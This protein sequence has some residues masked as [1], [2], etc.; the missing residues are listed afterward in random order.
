V[1]PWGRRRRTAP[2]LDEDPVYGHQIGPK[3]PIL[4]A[5]LGRT[6]RAAMQVVRLCVR[7]PR[8]GRS[9]FCQGFAEGPRPGWPRRRRAAEWAI[10]APRAAHCSLWSQQILFGTRI[11]TLGP[12]SGTTSQIRHSGGTSSG[13]CGPLR[14]L[15][16]PSRLQEKEARFARC[17]RLLHGAA[18]TVEGG[19]VAQGRESARRPPPVHPRRRSWGVALVAEQ[20]E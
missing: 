16:T 8:L 11:R 12:Y 1:R 18:G 7:R 2:S 13:T 9:S 20:L 5:K 19:K 15:S 6:R 3:Y 4:R 14:C 10:A 17:A